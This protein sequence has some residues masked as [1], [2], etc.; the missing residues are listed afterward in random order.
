MEELKVSHI[1]TTLK[2]T[3]KHGVTKIIDLHT[4]A[5]KKVVY[6]EIKDTL[7]STYFTHIR[8]EDLKVLRKLFEGGWLRGDKDE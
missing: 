4:T 2:Y 7:D 5:D 8:G 3:D 6:L 1:H